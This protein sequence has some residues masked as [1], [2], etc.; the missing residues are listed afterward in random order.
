MPEDSGALISGLPENLQELAQ[1]ILARVQGTELQTE[2]VADLRAIIET[3]D[4][5]ADFQVRFDTW[6]LWQNRRLKHY[7][8]D[9][10]AR[11]N[12]RV[13]VDPFSWF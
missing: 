11:H 3:R 5:D 13:T 4:Q 2:A 7:H 9:K 10:R 12:R 8:D 1:N 6:R